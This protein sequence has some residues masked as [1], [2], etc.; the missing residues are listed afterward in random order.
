[1][2]VAQAVVSAGVKHASSNS[3]QAVADLEDTAGQLDGKQLEAAQKEAEKARFRPGNQQTACCRGR[4]GAPR[5]RPCQQAL[6]AAGGRV[7]GDGEC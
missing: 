4:P 6:G 5:C 7:G 1:M 2:C 3:P